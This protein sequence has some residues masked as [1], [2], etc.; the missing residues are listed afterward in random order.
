MAKKKIESYSQCK[1]VKQDTG[2]TH[3]ETTGYIDA[4]MA[5]VGSLVTLK[6]VEGVWRIDHA[7]EAGK[8]P[9]YGWGQMD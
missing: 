2:D 3:V 5:K 9:N 7:G 8:R 4:K 1:F 6:G